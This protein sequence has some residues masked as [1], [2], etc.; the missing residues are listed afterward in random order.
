MMKFKQ[1]FPNDQQGSV[2]LAFHCPCFALKKKLSQEKT[3]YFIDGLKK[4]YK[5]ISDLSNLQAFGDLS[6]KN[7]RFFLIVLLILRRVLK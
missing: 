6:P 7:T 5:L 1:L 2:F 3:F 4:F